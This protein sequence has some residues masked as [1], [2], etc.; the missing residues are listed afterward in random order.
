MRLWPLLMSNSV[1][2]RPTHV[3]W[4]VVVT[5]RNASSYFSSPCSIYTSGLVQVL[6]KYGWVEAKEG[7]KA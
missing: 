5:Y 6:L 3:L 1:G 2:A 4:L 7:S